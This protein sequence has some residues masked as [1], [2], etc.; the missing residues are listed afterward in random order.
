VETTARALAGAK[1]AFAT[2]P[3]NPGAD[4]LFGGSVY[5]RGG[6]ALEAL[7]LTV[8][9]VTFFKILRQWVADHRYGNASTADFVA[10][11][12]KVSGRDLDALFKS[13][14]EDT[15]LPDLPS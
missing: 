2:P 1:D 15:G 7:R 13:W 5:I 14:L 8:G 4:N 3:A 11:A 10:L 6:L 12:E 9:D